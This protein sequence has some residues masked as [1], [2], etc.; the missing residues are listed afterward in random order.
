MT[1]KKT[2]SLKFEKSFYVNVKT[3]YGLYFPFA[4]NFMFE[5]KMSFRKK[6]GMTSGLI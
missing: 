5:L 2:S 4:I 6:W 3:I 1:T